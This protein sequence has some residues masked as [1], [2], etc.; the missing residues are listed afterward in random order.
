MTISFFL[1]INSADLLYVSKFCILKDIIFVR[2]VNTWIH[3]IFPLFPFLNLGVFFVDFVPK[4]LVIFYQK[5]INSLGMKE[6]W[7]VSTKNHYLISG[8]GSVITDLGDWRNRK[9]GSIE[10]G[11]APH[12]LKLYPDGSLIKIAWDLKMR[13][14]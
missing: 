1:Y 11:P 3:L 10:E 13:K 14:L 6:L 12:L 4:E 2:S 9:I 5:V 7:S 8:R